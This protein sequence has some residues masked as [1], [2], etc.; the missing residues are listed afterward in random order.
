VQFCIR[1][2]FL[3]IFGFPWHSLL[4]LAK[5]TP[6]DPQVV[7]I[8]WEGT[9]PAMP[10]PASAGT[11]PRIIILGGGF[12]GAYCAQALEKY[13]DPAD[14]EVL[15]IDRNNYFI[16]FPLLVEAGTGSLEPRH[17]VVS[18][19]SFLKEATFRMAEVLALDAAAQTLTYQLIGTDTPIPVHYDHLVMALGSVTRLPDVP[20]LKQHGYEMKNLADAVGLRDR[21]I[22]LLERAEATEDPELRKS[23]LHFVVVGGNFSGVEVAGEFHAFIRNAAR[24]YRHIDPQDC[25]VSLIEHSP[26]LLGPL[27]DE[28]LQRFA[29]RSMAKRGIRLHLGTGATEVGVDFIGLSD[30]TRLPTH[31]VIWCAGIA[32]NPAIRTLGIPVDSRGYIEC[33]PDLRVRGTGNIW[34]IGDCAVNLGPDGQPYAATAQTAVRTGPHLAKN[35]VAV[36]RGGSATPPTFKPLGQLA[37]LGCRTGVAK[38]FGIQLAGFPAWFLWRTVYLMKMPGLARKVRI[39]LDW[40]MDLFFPKDYVQ[41]GLH[42]KP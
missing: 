17:A 34:A 14:C 6:G 16:F 15:L 5:L 1:P 22:R 7:E 2:D 21:A 35:I 9:V 37:A 18:I 12:A 30:G 32:P 10:Q 36:M 39:A 19:R 41:L 38:V 13:L 23:L 11:K 31:T 27:N 20:G 24:R 25:T 8:S 33:E 28:N 3:I 4:P 42:R 26:L 29:A 40:T